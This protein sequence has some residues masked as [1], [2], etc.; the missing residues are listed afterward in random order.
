MDQGSSNKGLPHESL[1]LVLPYLPLFVL[2]AMAQTCKSFNDALNNDILPWLNIVVDDKLR[3]SRVTDE[4]LMKITSKAMGRLRSLILVNCSKITDDGLQNVVV[5]NPGINKLHV[6][7]CTGLTPEGIIKAVATV[8]QHNVTL[9]TLK[10]NGI[11]KITKEH[12]QTLR[13]LLNADDCS[14]IDVGRTSGCQGCKHCVSRCEECGKCVGLDEEDNEVACED[15]LCED[16]WIKL[17]KCDYC[18]KPYCNKHAYKYC[19]IPGSSN[20]VCEACYY[21]TML[22]MC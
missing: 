21:I 12:L 13:S 16:C 22:Y 14:S 1:Y 9:K 3:G 7:Q 18:T 5:N 6:P 10:I 8:N 4:I 20:F 2:L 19:A 15:M 17:P 11:S